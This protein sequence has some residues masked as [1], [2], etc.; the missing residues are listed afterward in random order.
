MRLDRVTGRPTPSQQHQRT[1]PKCRA[2]EWCVTAMDLIAQ[3]KGYLS[4]DFMVA[5]IRAEQMRMAKP[6]KGA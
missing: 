4:W 5:E 6:T 1:C 3:A 2:R